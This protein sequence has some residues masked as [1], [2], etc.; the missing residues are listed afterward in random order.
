MNIIPNIIFDK[1]KT[2]LKIKHIIEKKINSTSL[3]KSNLL[4]VIGGDGFM[5][6]TLKKDLK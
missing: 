3:N 4:I 1:T 5:L 2:S 6:Q